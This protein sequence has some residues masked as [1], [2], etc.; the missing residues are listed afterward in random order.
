[1]PPGAPRQ[2]TNQPASFK[3]KGKVQEPPQLGTQ[4]LVTRPAPSGTV[5]PGIRSST[6]R[7]HKITTQQS[8]EIVQTF[9]F[10]AIST[11]LWMRDLLPPEYFRTMYYSS[12]NKHCSYYDFTHADNDPSAVLGE[13]PHKGY[14]LSILRRDAS[15]RGDQIIN[16][17]V[18]HLATQRSTSIG[19]LA[20]VNIGDW[21]FRCDQS[22]LRESTSD[23]YFRRRRATDEDSGALLLLLSVQGV[24]GRRLDD[25]RYGNRGYKGSI[26]G[27]YTA[28]CTR[29]PQY[30]GS[31]HGCTQ[32]IDAMFARTSLHDSVSCMVSPMMMM[33]MPH[34]YA[35]SADSVVLIGAQEGLLGTSPQASVRLAMKI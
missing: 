2:A 7:S 12:I 27:S 4:I 35:L 20:N 8:Q 32:R 34:F 24:S 9:L 33:M 13:R 10:S 23:I 28:E 1:M 19:R 21:H 17:L 30:C 15:K 14:H 25:G 22:R 5:V 26:K 11:I 18:G 16:W 31:Q 29:S 3:G 6:K